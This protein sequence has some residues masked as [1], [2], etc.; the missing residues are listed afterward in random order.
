MLSPGSHDFTRAGALPANEFAYRGSWRIDARLGD[1]GGRLARPQLRRP[2]RLPGARLARAAAQVRVLLD[3][4]PIA[5]ARAGS[6]VHGGVVTVTAPAPLQP[7]RP[8]AVGHHVLT[9][10]R[11]RG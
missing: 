11:K 7:R 2:P 3:G 10:N 1:R 5:A 4:K 8:A 9:L 6:D